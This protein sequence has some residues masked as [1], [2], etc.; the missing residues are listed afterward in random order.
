[1]QIPL[2]LP[3]TVHGGD[4]Q[5]GR[6]NAKI[7][8]DNSEWHVPPNCRLHQSGCLISILRQ[9]DIHG[10]MTVTLPEI[11]SGRARWCS[12]KRVIP[13]SLPKLGAA[14][15][16][17]QCRLVAKNKNMAARG[18]GGGTGFGSHSLEM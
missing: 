5:L 18:W 9:C 8:D 1:M 10:C 4:A 16:G 11:G 3:H 17:Q 2:R 12:K 6:Q 14:E 15:F 13:G 7:T